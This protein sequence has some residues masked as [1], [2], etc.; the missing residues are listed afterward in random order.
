LSA[1]YNRYLQVVFRHAAHGE[2]YA[3]VRASTNKSFNPVLL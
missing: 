1:I 2:C 3:R